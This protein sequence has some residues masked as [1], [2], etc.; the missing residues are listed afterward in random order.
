M[1]WNGI[2]YQVHK[3]HPTVT[4]RFYDYFR[5]F[6]QFKLKRRNQMEIKI[7]LYSDV[8]LYPQDASFE[9]FLYLFFFFYFGRFIANLLDLAR[10]NT[11]SNCTKCLN[12]HHCYNFHLKCVSLF[13]CLRFLSRGK[14]DFLHVNYLTLLAP[15]KIIVMFNLIENC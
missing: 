10:V 6:Q 8:R 5:I 7:K 2:R 4:G 1:P 9:H 15:L 14:S 11:T 3:L 12:F 13:M